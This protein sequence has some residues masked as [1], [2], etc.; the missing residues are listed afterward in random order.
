MGGHKA[1]VC[2]LLAIS[3]R[4]SEKNTARNMV[5][6]FGGQAMMTVKKHNNMKITIEAQGASMGPI[7]R[8]LEKLTD[9]MARHPRHGSYVVGN[10]GQGAT[11]VVLDETPVNVGVS[12]DV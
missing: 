2:E 10:R 3:H 5:P 7:I 8:S 1:N 12:D 4:R 6:P 9:H 11:A